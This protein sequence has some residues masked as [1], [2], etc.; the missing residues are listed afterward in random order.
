VPPYTKPTQQGLIAHFRAVAESAPELPMIVYNVP[1]RTGTNLL[2]ATLG[3]IWEQ[4]NAVAIKESS[5]DLQQIGRIAAELP[6]GKTLLAGDDS[7]A[8]PTIAAGAHGLV[9]VAGNVLP[10]KLRD[11]VAAARAGDFEL[12]RSLNADLQPLFEALFAEP[13]PIGVKVAIELLGIAGSM[14]RLP[15]LPGTA[16]TREGLKRAMAQQREVISG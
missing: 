3:S 2:P 16:A 14:M 7:L 5:G 4:P 1:S 12:A 9:S 13:N 10:A 8:L 6:S 15:L 11:L